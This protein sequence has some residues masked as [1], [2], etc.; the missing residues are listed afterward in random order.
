[1]SN[2]QLSTNEKYVNESELKEKC[3]V[4]ERDLPCKYTPFVKFNVITELKNPWLTIKGTHINT[5]ISFVEQTFNLCTFDKIPVMNLF[6]TVFYE[7]FRKNINF[8]MKCPFKP[9]SVCTVDK[10]YILFKIL[11]LGYLLCKAMEE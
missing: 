2:F 4:N 7:L 6:I 8:E 1:M 9:V 11:F 3:Q 5:N 10:K